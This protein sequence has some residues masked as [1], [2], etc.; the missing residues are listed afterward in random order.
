[1][2]EAEGPEDPKPDRSRRNSDTELSRKLR[3][4]D[5]RIDASRP[6]RGVAAEGEVPQRPGFGMA[7]RLG[8]DFVAGVVVGAAIGW[9]FDRLVGTSPWG[10]AAFLLL[11]FAAGVLNVMRSAGLIAKRP[12][13]DDDPA[14]RRFK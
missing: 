4:L 11:G 10:L 1:M 5:R 12:G 6:T 13:I 2:S 3:D 9:G 14:A 7:L 8:G